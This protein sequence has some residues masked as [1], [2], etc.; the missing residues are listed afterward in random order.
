M[1]QLMNRTTIKMKLNR[2]FYE[3]YEFEIKI[4]GIA[5]LFLIALLGVS[6]YI[7]GFF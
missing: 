5:L 7:G 4:I 6:F 3:Y 1:G 2:E